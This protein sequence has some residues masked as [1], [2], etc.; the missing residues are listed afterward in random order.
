MSRTLDTRINRKKGIIYQKSVAPGP[1]AHI[2]RFAFGDYFIF[3]NV[4]HDNRSF[5]I[6]VSKETP[7]EIIDDFLAFWVDTL[8]GNW[9]IFINEQVPVT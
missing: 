9:R 7:K 6:T 8:G 1:G 4:D 3:F 5:D 2:A